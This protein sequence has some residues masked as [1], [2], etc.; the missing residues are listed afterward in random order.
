MKTKHM[1]TNYEMILPFIQAA[2]ANDGHKRFESKGYMPLSVEN[3]CYTD[4]KGN[5]VYS[6][7]HWGEQNGDLM[8]DPDMTFSVNAEDKSIRPLTFQNDYMGIYQEVFIERDGKT[9]YSRRLLVDLD[10]FLWQWLKNIQ[11]QGFNPKEG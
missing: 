3:L 6:I 8:H 9:L 2:D 1:H 10:D 4:Y 11:A 7:T 5:P